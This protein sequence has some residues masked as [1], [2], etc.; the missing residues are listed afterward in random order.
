MELFDEAD[1]NKDSRLDY[2]EWEKMVKQI[3][4]KYPLA[5]QSFEKM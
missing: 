5:G 1:S 3:K 2:G 4:K